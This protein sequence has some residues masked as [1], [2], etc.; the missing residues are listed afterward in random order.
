ML[1]RRLSSR[2]RSYTPGTRSEFRARRLLDRVTA[3]YQAV[4]SRDRWNDETRAALVAITQALRAR[5]WMVATTR[6]HLLILTHPDY[7]DVGMYVG[8][9]RTRDAPPRWHPVVFSAFY[10]PLTGS[11][12]PRL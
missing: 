4:L 8:K 3:P 1:M 5:G 2:S 10:H 9:A 6:G 11:S 12:S 7:Q